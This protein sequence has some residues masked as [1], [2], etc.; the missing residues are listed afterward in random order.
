MGY[1]EI[2]LNSMHLAC[3]KTKIHGNT[4]HAIAQSRRLGAV[5]E[6]MTE[7]SAA[8]AAVHGTAYHPKA[9]VARFAH[10]MLQRLIE[11]GPSGAALELGVRGVQILLAA[12][13]G[14]GALAVLV[15][16]GAGIGAFG[17]GLAK[18][19]VLRR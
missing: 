11:A 5:V 2:A 3:R 12:R 17:A 7:M 4:I 13:A 10:G 6:D 15:V 14:E 19:L 8:T 1:L 16:K 18:H 9:A